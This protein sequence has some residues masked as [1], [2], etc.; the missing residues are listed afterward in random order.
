MSAT[1]MLKRFIGPSES[2]GLRSGGAMPDV[3]IR[4]ARP[5]DADALADLAA[6]DS[7]RM[8]TGVVLVAEVGGT[9]WAAQSV[10]DRHAVADP[11]R[12]TSEFS[13][14]LSERARQLRG[15]ERARRERLPML[16]LAA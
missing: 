8:P 16:R 10:D 13:L 3:T 11:F 4:Y 12:H 2:A 15:A 7:S 6:M 9:L 5:D 1:T 14:L